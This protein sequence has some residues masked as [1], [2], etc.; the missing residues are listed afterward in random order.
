MSEGNFGV[1]INQVEIQEELKLQETTKLIKD[2]SESSSKVKKAIDDLQGLLHDKEKDED[3][4]EEKK[5]RTKEQ[6][7][8]SWRFIKDVVNKEK[9]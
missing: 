7:A 4:K 8:A 6:K 3:D 5:E 1:S 9:G 2:E